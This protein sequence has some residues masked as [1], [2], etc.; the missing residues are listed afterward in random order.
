MFSSRNLQEGR[1]ILEMQQQ[2]LPAHLRAV[3]SAQW[4]HSGDQHYRDLL[5]S[6]SRAIGLRM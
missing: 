5:R 3:R 4:L 2:K 6:L 1:A